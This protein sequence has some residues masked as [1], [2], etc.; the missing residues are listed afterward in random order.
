MS[1]IISIGNITLGGT[2]K[3]PMAIFLANQLTSLGYKVCV[4]SRGYKGKI[5]YDTNVI[6]DGKEILLKPPLAADE[7]YMIAINC[8]GCIVIT[9]KERVKS[10]EYAEKNFDIDF[11]LLDDGF[12]HRKMP[13]DLDIV[14]LDHKNPISTGLPFPFGYLREFPSALKR[15]DIIVFTKANSFTMPEKVRKYIKGKDIFYSKIKNKEVV[16]RNEQYP[17][18]FLKGK[19]VVAFSGIAKNSSFFKQLS[20]LGVEIVY[21]KGYMDHHFYREKDMDFLFKLKKRYNADFL[22]TTEKD[23]VKILDK[24][25]DDIAFLK[26]EISINDTQ[27]FMDLIFE[28]IK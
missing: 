1:K 4:L 8:P 2:G 10:F 14:L 7:P 6:S 26:I 5:G 21:K 24:Y 23:Y 28:K 19:K 15:A 17:I 22:I 11:Y 3:T 27:K 20:K 12:Q 13:R 9:G 25:R 16:F 18:S